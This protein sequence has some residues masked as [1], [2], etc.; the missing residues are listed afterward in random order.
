MLLSLNGI[1]RA[2]ILDSAKLSWDT[3]SF[4]ISQIKNND[5]ENKVVTLDLIT[6]NSV[7]AKS[8][9]KTTGLR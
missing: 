1:Y 3:T 5:V 4:R 7:P 6:L 9:R 8:G 2:V